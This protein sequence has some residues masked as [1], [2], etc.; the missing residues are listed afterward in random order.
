ME[1]PPN[2]TP[3]PINIKTNGNIMWPYLFRLSPTI[4][5][6]TIKYPIKHH[7][8][9]INMKITMVKARVKMLILAK[10]GV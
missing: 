6:L 7:N 5:L 8:P 2:K 10:R 9:I 3:N 1:P 4:L